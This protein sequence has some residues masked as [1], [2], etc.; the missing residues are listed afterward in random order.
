MHVFFRLIY[1]NES[2]L[3]VILIFCLKYVSIYNSQ[4]FGPG[5]IVYT[6]VALLLYLFILLSQK[7]IYIYII[8]TL[9]IFSMVDSLLYPI[10]HTKKRRR[11]FVVSLSLC[12]SMLNNIF[13]RKI[14]TRPSCISRGLKNNYFNPLRFSCLN[15]KYMW[16]GSIV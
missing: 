14:K 3:R 16:I 10:R 5:L 2:P 4:Y 15:W 8:C 9:H 1:K 13:K 7:Y 6:V 11:L 12:F